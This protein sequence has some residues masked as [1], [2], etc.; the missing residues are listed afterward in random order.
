[1]PNDGLIQ[2]NRNSLDQ[3]Q[4][5]AAAKNL[6]YWIS[7]LSM[8]SITMCPDVSLVHEWKQ[9]SLMNYFSTFITGNSE[10]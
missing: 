9:L 2:Q 1:M 6:E 10:S 8:Y 3:I 5:Q 4:Q 7:N